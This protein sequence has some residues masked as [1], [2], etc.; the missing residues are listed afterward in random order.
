M[1]YLH[2][3]S[4]WNGFAIMSV[5]IGLLVGVATIVVHST[6]SLRLP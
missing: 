1:R 3:Q 2:R 4:T 6:R 5:V